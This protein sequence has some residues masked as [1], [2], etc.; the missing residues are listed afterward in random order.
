MAEPIAR[1]KIKLVLKPWRE[2]KPKKPITC[3]LCQRPR[4]PV[5]YWHMPSKK[6]PA[7][8][9]SCQHGANLN[10]VGRFSAGAD[11]K[12]AQGGAYDVG[13][14]NYAYSIATALAKEAK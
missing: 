8:C 6:T 4:D 12:K 7:V 14:M 10:R 11:H 9:A 3:L 5:H 13:W 1:E 2:P